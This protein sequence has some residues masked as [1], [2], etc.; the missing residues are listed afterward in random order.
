MLRYRSKNRKARTL[1]GV[2]VATK[3][4]ARPRGISIGHL[5]QCEAGKRSAGRRMI[6]ALA[7]AYGCSE[8]TV[9]EAAVA[10]WAWRGAAQGAA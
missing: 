3:C 1:L 2:K 10:T 4:R 5:S 9:H 6:E 8:R 7:R